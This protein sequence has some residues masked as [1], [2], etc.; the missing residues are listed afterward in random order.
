MGNGGQEL[1]SWFLQEELGE[2]RAAGL[3]LVT[4][5]HFGRLW[6]RATVLK[7]SGA[8]PSGDWGRQTTA[9]V[10]GAHR[11]DRQGV[12]AHRCL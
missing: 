12:W 6:G 2:G 7:S 8:W 3:G 4:L 10:V 5:C 9:Q 11:G 1:V